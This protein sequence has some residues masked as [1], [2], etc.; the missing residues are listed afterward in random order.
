M[1]DQDSRATRRIGY[2]SEPGLLGLVLVNFLLTIVS[3]GL[4]RFWARTRLRRYFWS[5]IVIG[6]EPLEYTGTGRELFIGFLI[7]ISVLMPLGILYAVTQN[8]TLGNPAVQAPLRLGYVLAMG[9]LIQAAIFRARRYRLSRTAWRGINAG[10][11]GSTWRYLG[12]S[13]VN[14]ILC[15]ITLGLY[16]PW[17][18]VALERYKIGHS[19][20]GSAQFQLE[21]SGRRLLP[22][23]LVVWLLVFVPLALAVWLNW[24]TFA[25]SLA[26]PPVRVPPPHPWAMLLF[27]APYLA[28]GPAVIA[29]RVATFRYLASCT[30]LNGVA[31]HSTARAWPVVLRTILYGA[32]VFTAIVA[33]ILLVA[34]T[35]AKST[36]PGAGANPAL[37][38]QQMSALTYAM[39]GL[40]GAGLLALGS[41]LFQCVLV[42]PILRHLVSSLDIESLEGIEGITQNPQR[43]QRF[44]EGLADSFEVAG[45]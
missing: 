45:L 13:F 21:A 16:V 11:G 5:T 20:F 28:G 42:R 41:V 17:A 23:W 30:R 19:V 44:G 24:P 10:Q 8:L 31:L 34:G 6:D 1:P 32:V 40:V 26:Q 38:L 33:F 12:L 7:V 4:Y 15:L 39:L 9:A 37:A 3:L 25:H 29:Y 27:L 22:R 2:Q 43:R 18:T 35:L 14:A 36:P